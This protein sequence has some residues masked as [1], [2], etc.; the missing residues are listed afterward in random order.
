[1]PVSY[2]VPDEDYEE[3]FDKML[4]DLPPWKK[5]S[6]T[7]RPSRRARGHVRRLPR[8][9]AGETPE[10]FAHRLTRRQISELMT[11]KRGR[12]MIDE[13]LANPEVR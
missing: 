11:E 13:L 1:M 9:R 8:R 5:T 2:A 4:A 10:H 7:V 12:K 6:V 3:E